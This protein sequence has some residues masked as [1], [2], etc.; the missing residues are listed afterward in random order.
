MKNIKTKIILS[1]IIFL[2]VAGIAGT[3]SAAGASLYVSP[4]SVAKTA[5]NIFSASVGF[6]AA[7]NKVCAVE[8]TLVFSNLTC[9]SITVADGVMAQSSPT[10]SNPHFLIGVPNCTTSDKA[11]LTIS[12]KAGSAGNASISIAGVD[13]IGEG[14]SVGSTSTKGSYT[15][16]AISKPAT[17]PVTTPETNN[18]G[19]IGY[20]NG[21]LQTFPT[22]EAAQQAGATS[23]EPNY[24][25]NPAEVTQTSAETQST[26]NSIQDAVQ[27]N[28]LTAGV[29]A[30]SLASA[31]MKWYNYFAIALV[32]IVI[33]Y[34]IYYFAI[35]R[36]KK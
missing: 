35:K 4:A 10:C 19:F 1:V 28:N 22:L 3:A 13:I 26:D 6:T 9:Q 5:G 36:K 17:T 24:E 29:G 31:G 25:R 18:D 34:G 11:L 20:V 14:S 7:N 30:A 8:G 27:E 12:V 21:K 33:L 2:A 16:N 15:I 23:I 32:I